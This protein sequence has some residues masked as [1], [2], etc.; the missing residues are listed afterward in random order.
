ME[1]I[2]KNIFASLNVDLLWHH[3]LSFI[4]EAA[5]QIMKRF[6]L[7]DMTYKNIEI[8]DPKVE[9]SKNVVSLVPLLASFTSLTIPE[10]VKAHDTEWRLLR[11]TDL[12]SPENF[13]P[14]EFWITIKNAQLEAITPFFQ[15]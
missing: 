1:L 4:I 5:V 13:I 7:Q 2:H 14:I 12:R 3:C 15:H 8:L 10:N 9:K 6:P 11:N